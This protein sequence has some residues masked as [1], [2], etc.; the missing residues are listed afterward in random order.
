[1]SR[2]I[3]IIGAGPTG[4]GAAYRLKEL[5]HDDFVVIDAAREAGGLSRSFVDAKGF[6][7]DI[8]G[9]VQ[10]SHYA[11]FD[12]VMKRALGADGWYHHQRE[13][14]ARMFGTWVPYPV[15]NN[16]RHFPKEALARCVQGLVKLYKRGPAATPPRNFSEWI[17]ATFGEGLA[18][19]FM[20][21]YNF[22]V[23]AY[24]PEELSW[25]WI[26][27][28]VAVTDLERVL[29]NVFL[30]KDDVS[31]GPNNTFQ[32][33]KH[34]GTGAIWRAVAGLVGADKFRL[35][36]KVTSVDVERRV[37]RGAGGEEF[38]YDALISTMPVDRLSQLLAP[39]PPGVTEAA[40]KLVHSSTHVV[41]LGLA[42]QT[43]AAMRT[44][45]W[46]YFP[47]SSA[48][49]YRA[50]VFS[51]YSPA[52]VPDASKF[53]SLMTETSE[54]PKKPVDA[55]TLVEQTIEGALATGLIESRAQVVSVWT[56]REEY[57]YPTPSVDRDALLAKV[58]PALEQRQIF[59]RGRFGAWKYEVANQDHSMMQGVEVVNRLLLDV[60]ETTLRF[61][62]TANA[63]WGR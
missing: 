7:W 43:P 50:T 57:G 61:P 24:P 21:P 40:S 58:L 9:H 60:P 3:V 53:W 1:M 52:H 45:C 23:W 41:G 4:L 48:P 32:F 42:G 13:A 27:E 44:K 6:T 35:G 30:E 39:Q 34:G 20:R 5:G 29:N 15:Q 12:E 28:R 19:I 37:V 22:K 31:W 49:F 54:S 17:D 51:N 38:P 63:N 8:G 2:R 26:G 36:V 56:H 16:L 25:S 10:F 59:S 55:S 18:E 33:P 46:I 47:E 11:W 14:W 62:G